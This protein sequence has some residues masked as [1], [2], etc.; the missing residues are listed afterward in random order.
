MRFD[1]VEFGHRIKPLRKTRN[2]IQDQLATA[3]LRLCM[4]HLNICLKELFTPPP[5]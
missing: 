1:Q 3:S 4:F 5:R 2:L